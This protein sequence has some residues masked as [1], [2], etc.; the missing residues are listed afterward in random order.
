MYVTYVNAEIAS[1]NYS[2]VNFYDLVYEGQWTLDKV[3]ELTERGYVDV[4]G[5]S[6]HDAGDQYG[7]ILNIQDPVEG[8]A[9]GSN[10]RLSEVDD[11][12]VPYISID[13]E[14]TYTFYDKLYNLVYNNDGF[15][16]APADDSVST[17][18]MFASGNALMTVNKLYNSEIYLREMD[19]DFYIL[20]VPKLDEAQTNYNTRLHDGV[21]LFGIPVTNQHYDETSATLEA[22]ASESFRLVAPAYYET[23]LKVKYARDNESAKMIDLIRENVSSDFANLYSNSINN[24]AHLFRTKLDGETQNLS[25]SMKS[26]SRVWSKQLEKL[27]K[28][29]EEKADR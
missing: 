6:K 15:Y 8:M 9:A 17:M 10:I 22:M 4:N 20:P 29:L 7:F 18:K 12:G 2:D 5:D 3:S 19:Q 11:D 23:A 27:F 21:T 28:Q 26:N 1:D 25:S 16:K 13:N 24:I 14:R